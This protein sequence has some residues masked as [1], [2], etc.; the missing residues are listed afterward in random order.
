MRKITVFQ[1]Q[2]GA[3]QVIEVGEN[4][5]TWGEV[6]SLVN[7]D[8]TNKKVVVQENQ[9]TLELDDAKLP[10][11][12]V[13]LF[14]FNARSK[15]GGTEY[16]EGKT[17]LANI[18]AMAGNNLRRTVRRLNNQGIT[19]IDT[20]GSTESQRAALIAHFHGSKKKKVAVKKTTK[21]TVHDYPQGDKLVAKKPTVKESMSRP[22]PPAPTAQPVDVTVTVRT[23]ERELVEAMEQ[24]NHKLDSI[25]ESIEELP[26]LIAEKLHEVKQVTVDVASLSRQAAELRRKLGL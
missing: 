3:S 10:D 4:V 5:S 6:K 7:F 9:T 26:G 20:T 8:L 16:Y 13:T 12:N 11:G 23:E 17:G 24:L 14:I 22:E 18:K 1:A 19:D 25:N 15:A 2:E 21:K